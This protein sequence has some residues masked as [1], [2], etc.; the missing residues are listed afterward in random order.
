MVASSNLSTQCDGHIIENSPMTRNQDLEVND[1]LPRFQLMNHRGKGSDLFRHAMGRP[2]VIFLLPHGDEK[3]ENT[4]LS[5]V[6]RADELT[7]KAHV[8]AFSDRQPS[9][10][11]KLAKRFGVQFPILFDDQRLAGRAFGH[12]QRGQSGTYAY[13]DSTALLIA[14]S[15]R[16]VMH[17]D[18]S[19]QA[20]DFM[21]EILGYLDSCDHGQ[22]KIVRPTAPILYVPHV[23][24]HDQCKWLIDLHETAGNSPTGIFSVTQSDPAEVLDRETKVRRDHIVTEPEVAGELQRLIGKRLVPELFK[25]FSFRA[26]YVKEFKIGCY[27]S[28]DRGFFRPHRDNYNEMGGRRFA[29]TLNL[30]TESYEGGELR[31]PEYGPDLYR[32]KTGDAVVFSCYHV[33]EVLPVTAGRRYVLLCFLF[34]DEGD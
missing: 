12:A 21:V 24:D 15:N 8:F 18:R 6:A 34:G 3:C 33:H 5:I 30:N 13:K 11:A 16:R 1:F 14:D 32:P 22:P 17:I 10:S 7:A 4:L 29:M 19:V 28:E 25:A 26:R 2:I 27:D 23:L 31:F 9:D 20:P